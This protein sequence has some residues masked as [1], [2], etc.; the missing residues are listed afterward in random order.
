MWNE[1]KTFG[2]FKK[3][4]STNP[5]STFGKNS[6]HGEQNGKMQLTKQMNGQ[7]DDGGMLR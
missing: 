3:W 4:H 6:E 7:H 2:I 1:K 5:P